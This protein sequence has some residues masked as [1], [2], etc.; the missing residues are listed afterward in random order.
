M[1]H[2]SRPVLDVVHIHPAIRQGVA[3]PAR[4][5]VPEVQA[6][7]AQAIATARAAGKTIGILAA[8]GKADAYLEHGATMVGVGTDL[9]LL[10]AAADALAQR[11]REG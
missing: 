7:I 6:A 10:I 5:L 2:E 8:D 9:H 3:R 1:S 11:W 4:T